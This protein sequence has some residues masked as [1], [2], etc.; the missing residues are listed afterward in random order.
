MKA[1][2]GGGDEHHSFEISAGTNFLAGEAFYEALS[3][4]I[5]GGGSIGLFTF[6]RRIVWSNG[7]LALEGE[8][9]PIPQSRITLTATRSE[10]EAWS[11]DP[12]SAHHAYLNKEAA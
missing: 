12:E 10:L 5:P 1:A 9:V 7:A 3:S 6:A 4:F 8:K 11:R 2:G